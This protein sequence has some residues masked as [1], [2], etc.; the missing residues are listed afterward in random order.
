M[1]TLQENKEL[2]DYT[3]P[4]TAYADE[5]VCDAVFLNPVHFATY[6]YI[7]MKIGVGEVIVRLKQ[8]LLPNIIM[9][10]NSHY[11][12]DVRKGKLQNPELKK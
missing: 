4:I 1:Y 3:P 11:R 5:I 9:M 6:W 7:P 8:V 12:K 10:K 2:E